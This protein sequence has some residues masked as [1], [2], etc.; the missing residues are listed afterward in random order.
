MS[1]RSRVGQRRTLSS[2]RSVRFFLLTGFGRCQRGDL[3]ARQTESGPDSKTKLTAR[4]PVV[5]A[6]AAAPDHPL[7]PSQPWAFTLAVAYIPRSGRS[8][9]PQ[10]QGRGRR[11]NRGSMWAVLATTASMQS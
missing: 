4:Q 7:E 2:S 9:A 10:L 11:R 8:N 5:L 6:A 3:A 1:L